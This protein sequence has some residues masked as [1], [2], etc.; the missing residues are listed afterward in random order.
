MLEDSCE[1]CGG[2]PLRNKD[3]EE[4]RS[5]KVAD[6][7][8]I[9]MQIKNATPIFDEPIFIEDGLRRRAELDFLCEKKEL[10]LGFNQ[11]KSHNII[12]IKK[13]YM[14]HPYLNEVL[15]NLKVFL[16]EFCSISVSSKNKKK[17]VSFSINKGT[18]RLLN[19]DNGIDITL[20]ISENP[21]VQHRMLIADFVNANPQII[22]FSW[23]IKNETPET[24]IEKTPPQLYI[25]GYSINIPQGAFLQASKEAEISMIN[26]VKEYIGEDSGK[27]ADLFCGLGTFSYPLASNSKNQIISVDSS[28]LSLAGLNKAIAQNQIHNIEVINRNLFKYPLDAQEL[29]KVKI[30][31]I[32]PPRASAHEQCREIA[33]IPHK[34][35]P[36]KI[37][38]VSCNPNTFVYDAETLIGAGYE[39][40]RVTLVDQF[41]Y[42]NHQEL[43]ALFTLK[44]N[45]E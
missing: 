44:P 6:F 27:I 24:I 21:S 14:L 30:I 15:V 40:S 2:C 9:I 19:A 29:K 11:N 17:I 12:D 13:C 1:L 32:D 34:D 28:S 36:L 45:K 3:K 37:I 7:K 5:L 31:V 25:S 38:F 10:K 8:K 42:S 4:Y 22:R 26:K 35:L 18:V 33:K 41:V 20:L 43:I 23:Q 39:L 16:K